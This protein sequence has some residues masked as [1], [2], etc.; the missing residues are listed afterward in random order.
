V[1]YQ[2]QLLDVKTIAQRVVDALRNTINA[3]NA[4][5]S[6]GELPSAWGDPLAVEQVLANLIGNA[7]NYLDPVRPG[8]VKIGYQPNGEGNPTTRTYFVSDNGLGIPQAYHAKLFQALQRLHPDKAPGEGIGLAI[9]RRVLERL[10]GTIRVESAPGAGSNFVFT[11]PV[12]PGEGG[13][14]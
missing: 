1:E 3:K 14:S 10:G 11:L 6:I 13:P 4:E 7:L 2:L 5:V 12:A 9:V 8:R